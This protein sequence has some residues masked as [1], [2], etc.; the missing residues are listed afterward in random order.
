MVSPQPRPAQPKSTLS[1]SSRKPIQLSIT[2]QRN[3]QGTNVGGICLE[4]H[5]VDSELM[6]SSG[7]SAT[8]GREA[9]GN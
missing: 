1:L 5:D 8:L 6:A 3:R 2:V 4:L 9:G 7:E